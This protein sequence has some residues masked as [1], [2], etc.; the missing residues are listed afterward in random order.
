MGNVTDKNIALCCSAILFDLDGV[1]IDSTS[2]IERHWEEWAKDH[3]ID[4]YFVLQN[5]HGVR[6]IETMQIVAPHL[7]LEKEAAAF[8]VNEVNDTDGVVAIKGAHQILAKLPKEKWA[9]VTSGSYDLVKAR[10]NATDLPLP[11]YLV[12]A[13]E[14]K[15]GKPS[16]EPYLT[17]A[18][19]LGLRPDQCVVVEDSPIGVRAGKAAGIKVIGVLSTHSKYTLQ[20]AGADFTVN[21]LE[22]IQITSNRNNQ[23]LKLLLFYS[24]D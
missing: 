5:A 20:E 21:N 12:T 2:C 23:L 18:K 24:D 14:V 19:K 9:I 6:T 13:D 1:L 15:Q 3:N 22:H 10:L 17:G 16:P 4:L 7:E 8:T 11:T